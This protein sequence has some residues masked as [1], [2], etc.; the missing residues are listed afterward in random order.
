[1]DYIFRAAMEHI[2]LMES[3]IAQQQTTIQR[4]RQNGQDI[5][6]GVAR[7]NLL[8]AALEEMRI[9]LARLAPTEEQVAAPMWALR[10]VNTGRDKRIA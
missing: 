1:M 8:Y 2:H 9:Q 3:R 5:S 10:V 4:L 6:R 7:L